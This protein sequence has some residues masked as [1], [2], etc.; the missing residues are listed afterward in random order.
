MN[1]GIEFHLV[2]TEIPGDPFISGERMRCMRHAAV[3]EDPQTFFF[4][5]EIPVKEVFLYKF[6]L[7]IQQFGIFAD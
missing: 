4:Q 3:R 1:A 2:L 7:I 5:A 6:I